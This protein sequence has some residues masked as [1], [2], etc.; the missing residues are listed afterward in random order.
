[1]RLLFNIQIWTFLFVTTFCS[2]FLISSNHFINYNNFLKAQVLEPE[3]KRKVK[4]L[5]T[6][7]F[8]KPISVDE[9]FGKVATNCNDCVNEI[10]ELSNKSKDP[11]SYFRIEY[12][13]KYL[14]SRFVPIHTPSFYSIAHSGKW[15]LLYSNVLCANPLSEL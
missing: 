10:I 11:Q 3:P 5:N 13:L 2:S 8:G 14:E 7:P 4:I 15:R 12:L 6:S 9:P 1:M